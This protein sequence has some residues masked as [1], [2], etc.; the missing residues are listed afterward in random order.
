MAVI[1]FEQLR[2]A[3]AQKVHQLNEIEDR[4]NEFS[5]HLKHRKQALMMSHKE[6]ITEDLSA[7]SVNKMRGLTI[8]D[9]VERE[10]LYSQFDE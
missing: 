5:A 1:I 8:A 6:R 4:Q 9:R 3:Q 10:D 2:A 7:Q